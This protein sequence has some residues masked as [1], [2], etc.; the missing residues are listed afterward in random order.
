M[1]LLLMGVRQLPVYIALACITPVVWLISFWH[2]CRH[3]PSPLIPLPSDGRGKELRWWGVIAFSAVILQGVLGGLRVVLFRDQLGIFHAALAQ[4][5]FVLLCAI[6][7]FTSRRKVSLV[8]PISPSSPIVFAT[9]LLI[10]CQLIIGATMRHQHAGLAIP[11]FP[12][13]YGKIWPAMDAGSVAGYNQRRIEVLDANPITAFQIALQMTHRVMAV[14]IFAGAGWS[15]W[16][17]RRRPEL[18]KLTLAWFGLIVGQVLLGAV[19]IW[20]N[21]AADIATAHVLVGALSLAFGSI[22]SI[23]CFRG[24]VWGWSNPVK[25][26]R[27]ALPQDSFVHQAAKATYM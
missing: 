4:L 22:L 9:T 6:T 19:T 15:A 21:K 26:T 25:Q 7:L 24:L 27:I 5:F 10:F 17:G 8:G 13:A 18:R 2:I 16:V 20:S 1:V 11:D 23:I 3:R 14:L 12:L